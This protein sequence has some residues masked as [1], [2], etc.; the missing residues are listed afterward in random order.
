MNTQKYHGL[1]NRTRSVK[2]LRDKAEITGYRYILPSQIPSGVIETR[3]KKTGEILHLS[4]TEIFDVHDV[5]GKVHKTIKTVFME[6]DGTPSKK[7]KAE[8]GV[9]TDYLAGKYHGK[10]SRNWK[11]EHLT[12]D[13]ILDIINAG[14]AF[15]PGRFDNP[16]DKSHRS[17][18]YCAERS[19]IL[20]D[21]DEWTE[22]HPAP[23]GFDELL[24][25]Y[26]DI[27][28]D[29]YAATES[30]SSRSFLK[31]EFRIRLYQVFPHPILRGQETLWQTAVKDTVE[32]YPFIA[33]GVGIDKVRLSFGNARPDCEQRIWGSHVNLETFQGWERRASEIDK[34]KRESE[35]RSAN[36]KELQK[37]G[38]RKREKIRSEL[39]KRG[40]Q[41]SENKYPLD[42]YREHH[43]DHAQL[44]RNIGCTLLSGKEWNYP[45]SSQ[46]KSFT[47]SD[48]GNLQIFS[49]TMQEDSPVTDHIKS[50]GC[51][52]YRFIWYLEYG[53]DSEVETDRKELAERLSKAGYGTSLEDWKAS[54]RQERKEAIKAGLITNKSP[55][56]VKLHRTNG[57]PVEFKTETLSENRANRETATRAF[58]T[59]NNDEDPDTVRIFLV[60]DHTGTG[61]T[62]TAVHI[63]SEEKKRTLTIVPH[64]DLAS[65]M[66]SLAYQ[67]GFKRPLHLLGREYNY[68]PSEIES[69]P[70]KRRT[71]DLFETVMCPMVD[72][73]KPLD[74]KNLSAFIYCYGACHLRSDCIDIGYLSQYHLLGERD[75]IVT[76]NPSLFFDIDTRSYLETLVFSKPERYDDDSDFAQVANAILDLKT[77]ENKSPDKPFEFAVI[78]D[79][80]TTGLY[81]DKVFKHSHFQE[82]SKVWKGTPA[83]NFADMILKAFQF[84]KPHKIVKALRQ[85]YITMNEHREILIKQLTKHARKGVVDQ[86]IPIEYDDNG[87]LLADKK[88]TYDDGG[89][90]KIGTKPRRTIFRERNNEIKHVLKGAELEIGDKVIV[91]TAPK[92]ALKEG[93]P[94]EKITPLWREGSTPMHYLQI[95]LESIAND[96]NAPVTRTFAPVKKDSNKEPNRFLT[97]TLPPQAP[98]GIIANIAMLSATTNPNDIK[99]AFDG[100]AVE[101]TEHTGGRLEWA[102]GVKV[103]QYTDARLTT[104]SIFEYEKD[105]TGKRL[106]QTKPTGLTETASP[107]IEKLNQWAK[108]IDGKTAFIS[109]KEF[110]DIFSEHLNNFDVISHF[111]KVTGLN[112]KNLAFLVVFGYPKVKHD[113]IMEQGRRQYAND[114]EPLPKADKT[115][116]DSEGKMIPEYEQLT[117]TTENTENGIAI[118]ERRYTDPRL[119]KIRQQ[120]ATEKVIQAVGRARTSTWENTTTIIFTTLPIPNTTD[121]ATLFGN[122]AFQIATSPSDLDTA[123]DIIKKGDVKEMEARGMAR[124]TAYRKAQPAK[125][126]K[127]NDRDTEIKRRNKDGQSRKKIATEMRI[128]QATVKRVL[129]N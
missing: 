81:Y 25:R 38:Q 9:W 20:Y 116:L 34:E 105:D 37:Q 74:E 96:Q 125:D 28:K 126:K 30:I 114:N 54:Q 128:G 35:Q 58:I 19:L 103:Y 101:F 41:V 124:R 10:L 42:A 56:P 59:E 23:K 77:D 95:F 44:L 32:K 89:E 70:V 66:E 52:I 3:H 45:R 76:A 90:Q 29:F 4:Q 127:K 39:K 110:T 18:D 112:F 61:K 14:Y 102:D 117:E 88:I 83:G 86:L 107:R 12:L 63:A 7:R 78:D 109:Y 36:K 68:D 121:R 33:E 115:Q 53:L 2:S 65:Q 60:K 79:P 106:L 8:I 48:K 82:L 26:P 123:L 27:R 69:I 46:G 111:D 91:A 6:P 21:G 43:S 72:Q 97:L 120:L 67:A 47:L 13:E 22:E 50:K 84:R 122:A 94:L 93:V 119:D 129:D 16:P 49:N 57:T 100:Q 73:I 55:T 113:V 75:F 17:G 64:N 92:T 85:A 11:Q 5:D 15:A 62:H 40:I 71:K 98:V 31:P 104:G 87:K 1:V 99:R 118:T 51:N 80:T 24:L 108:Q